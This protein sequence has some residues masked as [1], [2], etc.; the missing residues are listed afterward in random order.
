[1]MDNRR[2]QMEV[3]KNSLKR[4]VLVRQ[5]AYWIFYQ[6]HLPFRV[7]QPNIMKFLMTEIQ[8]LFAKVNFTMDF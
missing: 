6:Q 4:Q 1:M 7:L 2:E 3:I 8:Q 5:Q